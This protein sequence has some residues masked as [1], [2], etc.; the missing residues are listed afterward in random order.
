MD[1]EG[2]S[3]IH[4]NITDFF[5][6]VAIAEDRSLQEKAFV[7]AYEGDGRSVVISSSACARREGIEKGMYLSTAFRMVPHLQVI[8]PDE[9]A[10]FVM[11]RSLYEIASGYTPAVENSPGGHLYLDMDGTSRL[12]GPAID[13]AVLMSRTICERLSLQPAV[14]VASNK[15]VAKI[16]TRAIRPSGITHIPKGEEKDFLFS[17]DISLLPGLSYANRRLLRVAGIRKIGTVADL[18]DQQAEALLGKNGIALRNSARGEDLTPVN[19]RRFEERSVSTRIDFNRGSQ[20]L[21]TIE[22]ALIRGA[23]DIGLQLRKESMG[24]HALAITIYW[25]D[26][27]VTTY[28]GR[29]K[30]L[31]VWDDQ[32]IQT[33]KGWLDK[34]LSRRLHVIAVAL[35][36]TQLRPYIEET[37]LFE[38]FSVT[39]TRQIQKS[40]DLLRLRFGNHLV[41]RATALHHG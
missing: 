37:E 41:T 17:Q 32:L 35:K 10:S 2:A 15:L 13:S 5:A 18:D 14:A 1:K 31:L 33:L 24:C 4:V 30:E 27:K 19:T 23:E 9:R 3:I 8:P 21:D 34:A 7:I 26:R 39:K 20:R 36:G 16:A 25:A 40:V 11:Q 22:A 6:S 29:S 38:E 28:T 12:F